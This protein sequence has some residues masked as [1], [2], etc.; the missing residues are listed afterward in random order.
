MAVR[1][2]TKKEE[3]T[4]VEVTT[5]EKVEAPVEAEVETEDTDITEDVTEEEVPEVD[6]SV[7]K[8]EEK[9]EPT[10]EVDTEVAKKKV[11]VK[12]D[13]RIRVQRDHRCF[14]GGEMY[15]LKA[16]NCY[17]VPEFV[18]KTLNRAGIL[19]PL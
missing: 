5:E 11:P 14:I 13:V 10:V 12:K 2:A 16:G 3:V 9:E 7:E 19:A 18:K 8:E 6:V 4:N 15:D 17:N 1:K